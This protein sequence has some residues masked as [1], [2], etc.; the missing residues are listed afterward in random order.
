VQAMRLAIS[1]T[2]SEYIPL[3]NPTDIMICIVNGWPNG[4]AFVLS[5]LAPLWT[6]GILLAAYARVAGIDAMVRRL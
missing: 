4:Y 6:I 5:F 1:Q 2:V 3:A